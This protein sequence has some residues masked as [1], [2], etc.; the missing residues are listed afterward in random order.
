MLKETIENFFHCSVIFYLKPSLEIK[1]KFNINI[2]DNVRRGFY[3]I[4]Q[5]NV[6]I[7]GRFVNQRTLIS[8]IGIHL[9]GDRLSENVKLL[10]IFEGALT[11]T[12]T[13][14]FANHFQY[15]P[16]AFGD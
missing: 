6:I 14:E 12:F 15:G 9:F 11:G 8:A 4:D 1:S 13:Q 5:D 16:L 10:N 7:I 2:L 3:P